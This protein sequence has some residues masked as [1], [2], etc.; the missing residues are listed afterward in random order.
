MFSPPAHLQFFTRR[1]IAILF[2][3]QGFRLRR[4]YYKL[5]PGLQILAERI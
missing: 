1:A 5:K 4:V 3:R 2:E